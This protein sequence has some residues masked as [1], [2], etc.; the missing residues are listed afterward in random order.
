MKSLIPGYARENRVVGNS[1]DI[2]KNSP[3]PQ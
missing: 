2:N 1:E 3:M